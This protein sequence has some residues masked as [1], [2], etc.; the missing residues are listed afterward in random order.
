MR[1]ET[2][3]SFKGFIS[4]SFVPHNVNELPSYSP[5]IRSILPDV[6][7]WTLLSAK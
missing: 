2:F 3:R 5:K 7:E 6:T 4:Y 1:K